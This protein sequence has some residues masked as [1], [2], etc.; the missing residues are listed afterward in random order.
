MPDMTIQAFW[1]CQSAEDW[2]TTVPSKSLDKTCHTV[3]WNRHGHGNPDCQ[4]DY[5]CDCQGFIFRGTCSHIKQVKAQGKRCGW[6]QIIDGG[7]PTYDT[8]GNP[9]CPKCGGPVS[10]ANWAV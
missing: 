7:T 2:E 10:A 1:H 3:R 9:T 5:S 4:L 8:A 6:R